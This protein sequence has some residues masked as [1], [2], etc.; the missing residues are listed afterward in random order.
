MIVNLRATL[1]VLKLLNLI[2]LPCG[3]GTACKRGLN[4]WVFTDHQTNRFERKLRPVLCVAFQSRWIQ[5][6]QKIMRWIISLSIVWIAFNATEMWRIKQGLALLRRT[7]LY[8]YVPP[9]QLWS[10]YVTEWFRYNVR[11]MKHLL[12]IEWFLLPCLNLNVQP[13]KY[14]L[15]S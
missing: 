9:I 12:G 10:L 7:R 5:S 8:K 1:L 14:F 13:W 11:I 3:S 6:K 2:S 4:D 15:L